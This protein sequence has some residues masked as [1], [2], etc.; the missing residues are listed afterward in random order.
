MT[1]SSAGQQFVVVEP[2]AAGWLRIAA[3]RARVR[4]RTVLPGWAAATPHVACCGR[5]DDEASARA[6][7]RAALGGADL[8]VDARADAVLVDRLCDDLT[9]LGRVELHSAADDELHRLDQLTDDGVALLELLA[10]GLSLGEAAPRLHL[11]RR[12]AD[13]RLA[14]AKRAVGVRGTVEAVALL[15]G[16]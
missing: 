12:T 14:E 10:A 6:A 5:V 2:A 9:R 15:R 16:P 7:L 4:G 1:D 13:R 8:L 3:A 11:S